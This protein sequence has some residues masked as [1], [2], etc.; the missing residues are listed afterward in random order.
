MKSKCIKFRPRG[1]CCPFCL[2]FR[3]KTPGGLTRHKFNCTKNP[4]NIYNPPSYAPPSPSQSL[5][6]HAQTPNPST[7]QRTPGLFH[8]DEHFN[9]PPPSPG[10]FHQGQHF[11]FPPHTPGLPLQD[12]PFLPRT[13]G[14]F[15]Q[16][17]P[18]HTPAPNHNPANYDSPRR[19]RWTQKGR[20]NIRFHPI[21]DGELFMYLY[22]NDSYSS[23]G[24]PCDEDGYDLPPNA[25]PPPFPER[26]QDDYGPYGSRADFELADFLYH[27]EQMS[28]NNI[29][30]LMEIWAAQQRAQYGDDDPSPPFANARDLYNVIDAT[31]LGDVPWQAISI[32]YDG[33]IPDN[34]PNWM[35]TPYE[36]WFRD[37][38]LVMESQIGNR[39]FGYELDYAPKKVF[40]QTRT[41]QFCDLMS[42]DWAWEQAVRCFFLGGHIR[43]LKSAL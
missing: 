32:T 26:P 18:P 38:L 42:G 27:K 2:H 10:L 34:P 13:P 28:G 43:K 6:S 7:P 9:F 14:L 24:H 30:K 5:G 39:D 16:D 11:D 35:S 21:L 3:C 36:V 23:L 17:F 8:Q 41:R 12:F 29:D 40:S 33:E 31:E 22:R 1:F 37:P 20:L 19:I 4:E 15:L 25:P